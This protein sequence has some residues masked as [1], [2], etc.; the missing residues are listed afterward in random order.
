[1]RVPVTVE[2][3]LKFKVGLPRAEVAPVAFFD[4]F[5]DRWRVTDMAASAGNCSM[6][7][8]GSFYVIYYTAMTLDTVFF[9][10]RNIWQC[11]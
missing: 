8:S 4:R 5:L 6:S 9:F 11:R 2:A 3:I 10:W 1:M 7:S